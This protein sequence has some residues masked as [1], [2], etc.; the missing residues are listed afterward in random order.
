MEGNKIRIGIH[1]PNRNIDNVE[2]SNPESGNPGI[3]GTQFL[4]FSLPHYLDN[5]YNDK[6]EFIFL[7]DHDKTVKTRFRVI[8]VENLEDAAYKAKSN[9]C[10]LIIYRPSYDKENIDF[11]RAIRILQI[12][13]I[14]W[15]HT[16]PKFLLRLLHRNNYIV[17]CVCVGRD[18][19]ETLR[20]HPIINKLSLINNAVDSQYIPFRSGITKTKSVV[21]L[22]SLDLTKGFHILVRHWNKILQYHPDAQLIVIGSGKLYDRNKRLGDLGLADEKYEKMFRK[23]ILDRSGT[24]HNSIKFMGILGSEKYEIMSKASVGIVNH[25]NLRETFCLA[26]VEFELCGTPVV[27]SLY[28]GLMDTVA[29]G[30][31]GFLKNKSTDRL[32]SIINLLNDMDLASRMGKAGRQ[33]AIE[34]FS[35]RTICNDW[36]E[37]LNSAYSNLSVKVLEIS[38]SVRF[39]TDNFRESLRILKLKFFMFRILMPTIYIFHTIEF[40]KL[41]VQKFC[42]QF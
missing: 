22:G 29:D 9:S 31:S 40:L 21:F 8:T 17:R 23:Y 41:K 30:I 2:L 10:D 20:D 34:K 6:F 4:H 37:L 3:G 16:T 1:L 27:S 14:A 15:M 26:A 11:L 36:V 13:T 28:G 25:P 12:K 42:F 38:P 18:Q 19:Y 35:Y 39:K 24:V 33:I 7:A 5:F 32:N